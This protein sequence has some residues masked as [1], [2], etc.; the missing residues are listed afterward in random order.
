MA[1]QKI[2]YENDYVMYITNESNHYINEMMKIASEDTSHPLYKNYQ[3]LDI[4]RF[5]FCNII[6]HNE[7]PVFFWGT[8]SPSWCPA[9]IARGFC[10]MYKNPAY[11]DPNPLSWRSQVRRWGKPAIAYEECSLW[12]DRY[13]ITN[14]LVTRNL[15]SKKDIAR[16]M[17]TAGWTTYPHICL[18][19]KVPQIVY[20]WKNTPDL[21]FLEALHQ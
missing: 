14:V 16:I 10:R 3:K 18:I 8:E 13:Q 19:N 15:N 20:S 12:L 17:S 6:V 5:L 2:Q 9:N 21:V 7:T 4:S 1:T 11:Q